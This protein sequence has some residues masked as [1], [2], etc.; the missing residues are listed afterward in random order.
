M[1]EKIAESIITNKNIIE[2]QAIRSII[3]DIE[4]NTFKSARVLSDIS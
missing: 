4:S 1:L 2:K 3:Q